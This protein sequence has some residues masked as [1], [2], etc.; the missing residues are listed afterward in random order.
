MPHHVMTISLSACLD[1]HPLEVKDAFTQQ[2]VILHLI[3][4]PRFS[5]RDAIWNYDSSLRMILVR[6]LP[7]GDRKR[8]SVVYQSNRAD[9]LAL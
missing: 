2:E 7:W 5:L 1:F 8:V 9:S 3:G 6:S 4:R